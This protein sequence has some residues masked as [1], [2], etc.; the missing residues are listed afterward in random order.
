MIDLTKKQAFPKLFH[1]IVS[2]ILEIICGQSYYC[3]SV[4]VKIEQIVF[5]ILISWLIP[6]RNTKN[7]V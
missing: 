3:F 7:I 6:P 4:L 2:I 5:T 1:I